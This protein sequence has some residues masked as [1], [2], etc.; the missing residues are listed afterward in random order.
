MQEYELKVLEQY[1]VN[2]KGTRKTRGAFF[3]DTEQGLFL[4]K[5]AGISEKRVPALYRLGELLKKAGYAYV[6]QIL[7]NAEGGYISVSEDGGRYILKH[8][9]YGREC[10]V[11]RSR[12]L[13]QAVKNLARLHLIM[14][15]PAE[16]YVF[17]ESRLKD[18]YDSH[19]RELRKVRKFVRNRTVKGDFEL[20]F[21]KEY[22]SLY[23][24]ADAA[25]S[26]LEASSY[27]E[28]YSDSIG[29]GFL[30]HGEYNYHNVLMT[31]EGIAT[32]N[33]EKFRRNVQVEDLYY[34]LRKTMEKH[35]W[36]M[37]LCDCMLNAYSA[38][39][40]ISDREME[41][42]KVRF[43]YPEKFWKITGS[44]YRSNKAWIA[45]KNV[46]KFQTAITQTEEKKQLL[47]EIFS[48][49]L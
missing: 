7:P 47:K 42:L 46:E 4:L 11:R 5:E 35:G 41:Y 45:V 40:P 37:H 31:T 6:D 13:S 48:F 15:M 8:W 34:F 44:Y 24:W 38:I 27:D 23:E 26:E 21:L 25:V 33:F 3:C 2:V 32:T 20:Q 30:V 19:N 49:R 12:E 14:V 9:Y 18:I 22:E 17:Q 39:R 43:I 28:L 10:D 36:N 1:D 16:E 29:S